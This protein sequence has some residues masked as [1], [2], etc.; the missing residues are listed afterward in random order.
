ME[1]LI[2]G[3]AASEG[4]PDAFCGC[5][6]CDRARNLGGPNLRKRCSALIDGTLLI[7]LGPDLMAAAIVHGTSLAGVTWCL[8]TH[9]HDD[10]FDPHHFDS[11]SPACGVDAPR[12]HFYATRGA[13]EYANP[14]LGTQTSP[15]G[16]F[17]PGVQEELNL[18]LHSIQPGDA[19]DVGPYRV[20]AVPASHGRNMTPLLYL[21]ERDGRTLF[22][23]TDTGPLN[24]AAW[25][26]LRRWGGRTDVLVLDHTFGFRQRS[27]GH[28][29]AEQFQEEVARLSSANLLAP[30]CRIFAHHLAHHSN[31]DHETLS[32]Y[33]AEHGYAVA[34]DGLRITI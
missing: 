13:I 11:R 9:E 19:F 1:L 22:Y 23:A 28:L 34:Y 30:D 17:D 24:E 26:T 12:L 7:D 4:Y 25:E 20:T 14:I 27:N 29:N 15:D 18:T 10:H 31:P 5:E 32:T 33:A 6:N 8:Q 21:I 16:L 2:L 3:T